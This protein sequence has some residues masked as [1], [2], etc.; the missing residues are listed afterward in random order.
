MGK[1]FKGQTKLRIQRTTNVDVTG[2][3]CVIKYKKPSGKKGSWN[4]VIA[5]NTTGIIYF[6]VVSTDTLDE[7]GTWITW[8]HVTWEDQRAAAGEIVKMEIHT[9]GT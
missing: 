2:G 3:T 6:D 1:I 9:E 8:A 5:N 4:A 7:I